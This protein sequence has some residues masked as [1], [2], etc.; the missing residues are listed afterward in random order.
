MKLI[1]MK[2][3]YSYL[4]LAKLAKY[5]LCHISRMSNSKKIHDNFKESNL[6]FRRFLR[7]IS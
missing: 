3:S 5:I 6:I 1:K 7:R 2:Q 4:L